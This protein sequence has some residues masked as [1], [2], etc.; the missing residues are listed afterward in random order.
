MLRTKGEFVGESCRVD[1]RPEGRVLGRILHAFPII[2][3]DVMKV[4]ETLK[5]IFLGDNAVHLFLL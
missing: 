2:I 4:L 1:V 3:D 5:V